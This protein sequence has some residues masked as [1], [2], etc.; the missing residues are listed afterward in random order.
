MKINKSNK[1]NDYKIIIKIFYFL[2]IFLEIKLN[3]QILKIKLRNIIRKLDFFSDFQKI[4][5]LNGHEEIP[6]TYPV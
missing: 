1:N 4:K 3:Y 6:K 5:I 2:Y